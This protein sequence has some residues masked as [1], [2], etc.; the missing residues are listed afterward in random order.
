M[1]RVSPVSNLSLQ[2]TQRSFPRKPSPQEMTALHPRMNAAAIAEFAAGWP[3]GQ[4]HPEAYL[5]LQSGAAD[6]GT[7]PIGGPGAVGPAA[8]SDAPRP[9]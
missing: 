1:E 2:E 6:Q 9:R 3:A 5:G 7:S 4:N 8:K